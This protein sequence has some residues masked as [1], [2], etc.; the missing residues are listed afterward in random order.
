MPLRPESSVSLEV[1]DFGELEFACDR[2]GPVRHLTP[3]QLV[4]PAVIVEVPRVPSWIRSPTD[5]G[6]GSVGRAVA[7]KGVPRRPEAPQGLDAAEMEYIDSRPI[8]GAEWDLMSHTLA[9]ANR[10]AQAAHARVIGGEPVV[11]PAGAT[12]GAEPLEG[13]I[14]ERRKKEGNRMRGVKLSPDGPKCA[15]EGCE[16]V[17]S[18]G[19]KYCSKKHAWKNSYVPAGQRD[20]D[21]P[22]SSVQPVEIDPQRPGSASSLVNALAKIDAEQLQIKIDIQLTQA[23]VAR[24]I[25]RLDP[26]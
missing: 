5:T 10:K 16:F 8:R 21:A 22:K 26:A 11:M 9:V 17:A 20:K 2:P 12:M 14:A 6:P 3:E 7:R 4:V 19:K 23:E 24:V 1:N 15:A 18:T 13:F 25:E